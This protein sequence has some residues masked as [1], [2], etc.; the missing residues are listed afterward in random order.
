V[1]GVLTELAADT[2]MAR[3]SAQTVPAASQAVPDAAGEL[4]GEVESFLTKV[5][6]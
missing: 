2:T 1:V 3:D 5:A 6:V 4:R